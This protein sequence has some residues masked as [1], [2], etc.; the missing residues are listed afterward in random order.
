M[1]VYK[2]KNRSGKT[3]WGTNLAFPD[4]RARIAGES[5]SPA[6]MPRMK[7]SMP[8]RYGEL[9]SSKSLT[10]KAG[11]GVAAAPPETLAMLL[12]KFFAQHV[13]DKLAPKTAERYC[14]QAA[15]ISPELLAMPF[16]DI[17]PCIS[18]GMEAIA[19]IRGHH[20]RTR[21]PRPLSKKT[22]RNIAGVLSSAF[23]RAIRWGLA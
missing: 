14:E 16:T 22:V 11:S 4:R 7:P 19:G 8:R 6:S 2:H 20:R 21:L 18:I 10:Q 5:R 1:S 17:T 23:S 13:D 15:Y 3:R 9:K 12:G